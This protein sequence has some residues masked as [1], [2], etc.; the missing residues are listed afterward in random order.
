MKNRLSKLG[1]LEK[2]SA[3]LKSH[4]TALSKIA[5]QVIKVVSLLL[6]L[7]TFYMISYICNI[8]ALLSTRVAQE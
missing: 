1:A 8:A 4:K 3:T 5:K 6:T 7:T 2:R